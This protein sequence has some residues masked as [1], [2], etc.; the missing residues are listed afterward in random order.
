MRVEIDLYCLEVVIPVV[1]RWVAA[2]TTSITRNDLAN[3]C[4]LAKFVRRLPEVAE[5]EKRCFHRHIHTFS[6]PRT[7]G[8][9]IKG[10]I[11]WD[12]TYKTMEGTTEHM[13][14]DTLKKTSS[15]SLKGKL[16]EH[17]VLGSLVGELLG[18]AVLTVVALM[19]SN[20]PIF[21]PVAVIVLILVFNDLSGAHINPVVTVGAWATRQVSWVKAVGFI[22]AQLLGAILAYV[23]VAKFMTGSGNEVFA[24]FT[25]PSDPAVAQ[26]LAQGRMPGEW[27]PIWGELFGSVVF[28]FGIAAALLGRKVGFDK[29]FTIGG[30]LMLGLVAALAGSHAV[31]NPAVAMALSAF[32]QGGFWSFAA[33]AI[34]P[35][36]GG[37]L[38]AGLFKLLKQDVDTA[39]TK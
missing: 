14:K 25:N 8:V 24:L 15:S 3:A 26:G 19:F 4:E 12:I 6:I 34:A 20:N 9:I 36:V 2:H 13:A 17:L 28:G 32:S 33:Y 35:L 29:A 27:K 21:G 31:L 10:V 23:I 22:V 1:I 11:L 5:G 16:K 18:S 38:G 30:A 37:M 7:C 39:A